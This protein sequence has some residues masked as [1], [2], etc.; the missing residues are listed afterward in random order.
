MIISRIKIMS[1]LDI[2]E[3]R[4]PQDGRISISVGKRDIDL[5]VS[6]LPSSFGERVVLRILEKDK[7]HIQLE[8]LG[9]SQEILINIS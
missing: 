6:T 3:R 5:R 8:Q 7:T 1:K 9:F 4:L 2:S